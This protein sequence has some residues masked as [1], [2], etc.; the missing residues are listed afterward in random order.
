MQEVVLD[1]AVVQPMPTG[2][3]MLHGVIVDALIDRGA[4][5]NVLVLPGAARYASGVHSTRTWI[6]GHVKGAAATI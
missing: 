6:T 3:S 2:D 1:A 5:C 4:Q